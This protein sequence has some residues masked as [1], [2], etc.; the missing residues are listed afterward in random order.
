MYPLSLVL[1]A[2]IGYSDWVFKSRFVVPKLE[3][4]ERRTA[5]EEVEDAANDG[6][7]LA[8]ETD[9]RRSLDVGVLN[10][11]VGR[12]RHVAGADCEDS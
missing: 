9:A 8:A 10:V 5:S 12:G 4:G 6:L 7:L 1:L 11:Q 2:A 3:L